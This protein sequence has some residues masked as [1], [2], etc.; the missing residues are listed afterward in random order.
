MLRRASTIQLKNE[1]SDEHDSGQKPRRR[2]S[3]VTFSGISEAD[4][5]TKFQKVVQICQLLAEKQGLVLKH[6]SK[7]DTYSVVMSQ[8]SSAKP[9][10]VDKEKVKEIVMK[11]LEDKAFC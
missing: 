1:K 5:T 4:L 8:K 2:E 9:K 3:Q 10:A 7:A 11:V 6:D